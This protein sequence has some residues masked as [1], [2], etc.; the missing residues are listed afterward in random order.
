MAVNMYD[1][2]AWAKFMNTYVPIPFQELYTLGAQAKADVEKAAQ[3]LSGNIQ[4]W[5]EFK[6]PSAKDTQRFYDLTVGALSDDIEALASNPD[7][8]KTAEGRYRLQ[9]K[10]NNLDY[11]TLGNIK[12]SAENLSQRQRLIAE[13]EAKGLYNRNWDDINIGDWDTSSQGIMNDLSPI[14][15][16]SLHDIAAPYSQALKDSY[17]G[18]KDAYTYWTGVDEKAIRNSINN[19]YADFINTP[20]G[21]MHLRDIQNEFQQAGI[22]ATPQEVRE[23]MVNR[24]VQSQKDYM[25]K[26]INVDTAALQMYLKRLGKKEETPGI[27]YSPREQLSAT[28]RSEVKDKMA[29]TKYFGPEYKSKM[30]DIEKNEISQYSD[31]LGRMQKQKTEYDKAVADGNTE[32]A[33]LHADAYGKLGNYLA[34]HKAYMDNVKYTEQAKGFQKALQSEYGTDVTKLTNKNVN[35]GDFNKAANRVLEAFSA[36]IPYEAIKRNFALQDIPQTLTVGGSKKEGFQSSSDQLIFPSDL[37]SD[38]ANL[39][40]K[41]GLSRDPGFYGTINPKDVFTG[42]WRTGAFQNITFVPKNK[43]TTYTDKNG[44]V[45]EAASVKA[46]IPLDEFE[47]L[48]KQTSIFNPALITRGQMLKRDLN[49]EIEKDEDGNEYVVLDAYKPMNLDAQTRQEYDRKASNEWYGNKVSDSDRDYQISNAFEQ[50]LN[51]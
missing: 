22:D 34:T 41:P 35:R 37:A 51:K 43:V 47:K 25:R 21:R 29:N 28:V 15:Y 49:A 17:L 45:I 10:I 5:S 11:A 38:L 3:N 8:L 40:I 20:Q 13:M 9:S 19:N 30:N 4:R 50:Y 42:L 31:I 18:K 26:N 46:Y 36:D 32:K 7:L 39:K 24:M 16:K 14:Q 1:Q 6:S 33:K 27:N 23:E 2:P 12:Q 48:Y 44:D